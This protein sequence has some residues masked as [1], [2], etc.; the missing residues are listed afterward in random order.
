MGQTEKLTFGFFEKYRA[1]A[2]VFVFSGRRN[3]VSGVKHRALAITGIV[4][5]SKISVEQKP[6]T[7]L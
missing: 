1:L 4:R 6:S 7:P 2:G 3:I 5:N